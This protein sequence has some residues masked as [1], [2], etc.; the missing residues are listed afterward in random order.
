MR[1]LT[2]KTMKWSMKK[3]GDEDD[4]MVKIPASGRRKGTT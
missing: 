2:L 1:K 4:D 3:I